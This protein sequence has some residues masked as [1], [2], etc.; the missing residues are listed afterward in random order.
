MNILITGGTGFIGSR[1]VRKMVNE[2]H[3]MYVLTRNIN[4]YPTINNVTYMNY[5]I[6][7]ADLPKID[8]IVN[9]AGESI[10]GYWSKKKM[11]R[12]MSSRIETTEKLITLMAQMKEKP[13]TFMT[14]SA[15]GYY[16]IST[17]TIFTEDTTVPGD[18]FLATVTKEW[19][20]TA[21]AAEEFGI[22]T[23]YTRF[24]LVLD[25]KEGSLPLM[26]LPF[27]CFVGG[28]IGSG[29]QW[30]SWIHIEDCVELLY[31]ALTEQTITG[32][33]NVTAPH[34][35]RNIDFSKTLA[36]VTHRPALIRAP[37]LMFKLAFGD[38]HQLITKGQY[39]LPQKALENHFPFKYPHL[40]GALRHLFTP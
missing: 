17:S 31:F 35:Q 19:E 29:E 13:H 9:L 14:G 26:A 3:H 20:K 1:F 15:V 16:G 7:I 18:D 25:K 10:F 23:V 12:I 40:E 36:T 34:P 28:K 32:P 4:K 38:M 27:K 21:R 8:A 39:V 24:G 37:K 6:T 22:R 30:I 2:G 33:I 5:H 11:A